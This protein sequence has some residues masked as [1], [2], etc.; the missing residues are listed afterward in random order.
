[1]FV[2]SDSGRPSVFDLSK[3]PTASELVQLN[4]ARAL[5]EALRDNRGNGSAN[6]EKAEL[7]LTHTPA[8]VRRACQYVES[9]ED[10]CGAGGGCGDAHLARA[11]G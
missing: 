2:A 4:V 10:I 8:L 1:M 9:F 7:A 3:M 11:L 5:N 6:Q